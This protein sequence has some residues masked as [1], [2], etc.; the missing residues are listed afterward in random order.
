MV[1]VTAVSLRAMLED[2][3]GVL[4]A[5]IPGPPPPAPVL[6]EAEEDI[7]DEEG[8]AEAE[9]EEDGNYDDMPPLEGDEDEE[10]GQLL[11]PEANEAAVAEGQPGEVLEA[12]SP[13]GSQANSLSSEYPEDDRAPPPPPDEKEDEVM[14]PLAIEATNF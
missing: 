2:V 3:C 12:W 14:G 4:P 7:G 8:A 9:D 5:H 10:D 1:T 6:P 11:D 13:P